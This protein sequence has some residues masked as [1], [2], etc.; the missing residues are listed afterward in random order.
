MAS[1]KGKTGYSYRLH[2]LSPALKEPG[3]CP[4]RTVDW[5][6]RRRPKEEGQWDKSSMG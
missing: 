1:R 6:A 4:R 5:I 2:E 3:V